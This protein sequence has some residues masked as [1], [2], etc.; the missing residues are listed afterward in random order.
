MTQTYGSDYLFER[1]QFVMKR[2]GYIAQRV[3]YLPNGKVEVIWA[4]K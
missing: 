3:E 1:A 2:K 4:K